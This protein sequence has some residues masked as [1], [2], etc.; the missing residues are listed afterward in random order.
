[1]TDARLRDRGLLACP[2]CD[3]DYLHHGRVNVFMRPAEDRDGLKVTVDKSR[4]SFNRAADWQVARAEEFPGRRDHIEIQMWC[5]D[6]GDEEGRTLII[7]Q[8]KGCTYIRWRV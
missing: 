7:I 8:H 5:E 1:M 2:V 4:F 6:C 3:G